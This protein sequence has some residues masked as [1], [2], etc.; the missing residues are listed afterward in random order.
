[1]PRVSTQSR[2]SEMV[3][4]EEIIGERLSWMARLIPVIVLA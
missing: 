3:A 4:L 2:M 1:M